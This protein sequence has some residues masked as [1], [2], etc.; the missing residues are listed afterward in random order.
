MHSAETRVFSH[1]GAV[2]SEREP[3]SSAEPGVKPSA[4]GPN[5]GAATLPL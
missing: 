4:E 2:L 5:P 1:A 3:R